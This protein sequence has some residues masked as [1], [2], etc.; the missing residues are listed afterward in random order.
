MVDELRPGSARPLDIW[1]QRALALLARVWLTIRF[2]LLDRRYGRLTL[3]EIEGVPI[4]VLP[5][6]FNPVLLRSG[7]FMVGQLEK[8]SDLAAVLASGGN[9]LDLGCG[10]GVGAV[11]AARQGAH[12]AAVD[13]N[14]E[15]VR[16]ARINALMHDLEE[17]IEVLHGDLF[18]PVA[19]R[20]FDLILFNPPY[21]RGEAR[22]E[23]DRAWR[24]EDIFERFSAG[25]GDAL[26]PG[27]RALVALS[28]DGDGDHLL[29]LLDG[30]GYEIEVAGRRNLVNEVLTAYLVERRE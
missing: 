3:E 11:F 9:V 19:F 20:Q 23:L 2:R 8:R 22:D 27:G 10:S 13:I 17:R 12:V 7:A 1:P 29:A 16:C 14:L 5:Q 26:A 21:Y 30:S 25:L 28:S 6:V 24:G 4:L 18:E 15:A